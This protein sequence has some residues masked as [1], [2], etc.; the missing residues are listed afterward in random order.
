MAVACGIVPVSDV[1]ILV[2]ALCPLTC[3]TDWAVLLAFSPPAEVRLV[4][5]CTPLTVL[6][7]AD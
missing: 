2:F 3:P 4:L 5:L 1:P 7:R 6:M